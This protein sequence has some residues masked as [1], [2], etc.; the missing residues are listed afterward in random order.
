MTVWKDTRV[1]AAKS[2]AA[3]IALLNGKKPAQTGTVPNG[4]KKLPAYIIPPVSITKA[5]FRQL[6]NGY[7]KKSE[8]CVGEYKKYCVK[9]A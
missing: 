8:V 3:A 2:A 7:L 6:F 1:L 9:P 5:N 4:A